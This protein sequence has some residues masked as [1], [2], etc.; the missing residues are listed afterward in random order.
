MF[1]NTERLQSRFLPIPNGRI[2]LKLLLCEIQMAT[3]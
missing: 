2:N 3:Q 1:N